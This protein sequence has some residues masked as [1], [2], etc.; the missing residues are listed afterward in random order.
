MIV[1]EDVA[2]AAEN[3]PRAAGGGL[4]RLAENIP[5]AWEVVLMETTLFTAAAYT[6]LS[7]RE[8]PEAAVLRITGVTEALC[9][10]GAPIPP[11]AHQ[12]VPAPAAPPSRQ[13]DKAAAAPRI[14]NLRDL[15][16]F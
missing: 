14:R 13:R 5:P 4:H 15:G 16:C 7:L 9:P 2:I 12:T 11:N 3:K 1:G 8:A 10:A 6:W